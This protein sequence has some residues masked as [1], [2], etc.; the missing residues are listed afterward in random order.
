MSFVWDPQKRQQNIVKHG[1]DLLRGID[2]FD[3]RAV[4]TYPSPRG[5]EARQVTVGPV[6]GVMLAL[7]WV[8]RGAET[9]LIS[10]RR[11]RDAEKAAYAIRLG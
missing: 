4:F 5:E 3:G 6:D 2:L 7:V 9:R 11:A 10:L 8:T 1:V